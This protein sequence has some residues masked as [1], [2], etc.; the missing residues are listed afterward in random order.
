MTA[1]RM[2]VLAA[3]LLP[4]AAGC[5]RTP[6]LP[7]VSAADSIAIVQDNLAHRAEA[8][9]W[10]R[11]GEG[12]P[13]LR[14]TTVAFTG[15]KWYPVDPRMVVRSAIHRHAEQ[16]TV[17]VLGTKGEERRQLKYGYFAFVLPDS[18]GG[19]REL[20]L[21]VYKF[22]PH[23][24]KRYALYPDNLSVWFTDATTG[25]ETYAVGRYLELGEENADPSFVYT[26][27]FNKAFNPYCAYSHLYSCAIPRKEDHLPVPV[28]AGELPYH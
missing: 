26:L 27:D 10:C 14:D 5:T 13:F 17:V 6:S 1:A 16:E 11:E 7:P 20:R 23:D 28:R 2:L 19:A 9:A 8:E 3:A 24:P 15:L 25:K 22:T 12:S 4:A 18:A 21:N